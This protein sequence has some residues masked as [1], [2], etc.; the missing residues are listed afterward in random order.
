MLK[1]KQSLVIVKTLDF[2][3]KCT[4][5]QLIAYELNKPLY[6]IIRVDFLLVAQVSHLRT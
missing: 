2:L 5:V 1:I 3:Q 6:E 4:W